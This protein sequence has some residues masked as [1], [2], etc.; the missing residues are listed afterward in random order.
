M[1]FYSLSFDKV[2]LRFYL[3]M[4]IVIGSFFA[5]YP[6]LA[7]LSVPVFLSIMAGVTFKKP[8]LVAKLKAPAIKK[9]MYTA[10]SAA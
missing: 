3:M 2:I 4:A 9:N 1:E 5:G 6:V 8:A 7:I 10:K